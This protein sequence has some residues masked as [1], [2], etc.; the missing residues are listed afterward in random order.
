MSVVPLIVEPDPDDADCALPW[1]DVVIAGQVQRWLLDTGAARS[2]LPDGPLAASLPVVG[3]HASSG[4]FGVASRRL[5]R[6]PD[7]VLGSLRVPTLDVTVAGPEGEALLG[8]DVLGGLRF[9]VRLVTGEL[10]LDADPPRA[11][12]LPLTVDAA[13]HLYLTVDWPRVT[14]QACWDS[15][16]GMTLVDAAF[17][18]AHPELFVAVGSSTG[19]DATGQR[20]QAPTYLMRGAAVGGLSLAAHRVAVVDLAAL[21]SASGRTTDLLLGYPTLRQGEWWFDVP[22]RRWAVIA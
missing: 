21:T 5:V 19:Q 18:T 3:E 20:R 17:H 10:V 14:A 15:G 22:G 4:V 6:A 9:A 1:V 11:A 12:M 7:L 2:Q 8:M 16:S 13:S